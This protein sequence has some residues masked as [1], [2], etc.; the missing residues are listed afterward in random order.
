[1]QEGKDK[2][3]LQTARLSSK[4]VPNPEAMYEHR[5][6]FLFL[7]FGFAFCFLLQVFKEISVKSLADHQCNRT[8]TSSVPYDKE[9]RLHKR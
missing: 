5:E 4:I 3:E 9:Y 8:G 1:M 7:F 2:A 6:K